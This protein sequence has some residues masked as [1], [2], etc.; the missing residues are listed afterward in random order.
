ME[1][2]RCSA[3]ELLRTEMISVGVDLA[4]GVFWGVGGLTEL[5]EGLQALR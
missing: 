3:L 4:C 5:M 1:A 2:S